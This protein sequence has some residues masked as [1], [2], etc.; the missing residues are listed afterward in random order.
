MPVLRQR[1]PTGHIAWVF[2]GISHF[3]ARATSFLSEGYQ[4]GER[5]LFIS[6]NPNPGL[7]PK[8]LV[9]GSVL[10]ILSTSEVYGDER[11]VNPT[12][13]RSTFAD[14]LNDAILHGYTGIRVAA[15][16]SSLVTSPESLGAWVE[17][18]PIADQFMAENPVTGLCGFD[19]ART[20]ES[21]LRAMM[22]LHRT[23]VET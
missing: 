8:R 19:R 17:W 20:D 22:N 21:T 2:S 4:L 15:D 1:W 12:E 23:L 16:N 6:D 3:E 5:L 11:V 10:Q 18:E 13:Q 14:V 9:N 7:W